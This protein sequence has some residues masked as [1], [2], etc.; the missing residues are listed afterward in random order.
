MSCVKFASSPVKSSA[1]V[2][3]SAGHGLAA[4]TMFV[5]SKAL[6]N[7]A[8]ATGCFMP[9]TMPDLCHAVNPRS[10]FFA[11]ATAWTLMLKMDCIGLARA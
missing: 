7:S 9:G 6:N 3:D 4:D 10:V 2:F 5:A 11:D 8:V 1:C